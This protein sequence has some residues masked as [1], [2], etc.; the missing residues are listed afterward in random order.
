MLQFCVVITQPGSTRKS[1]EQMSECH[2]WIWHQVRQ[3]TGKQRCHSP[4]KVSPQTASP[5]LW[6]W[7]LGGVYAG[8][9]T[10]CPSYPSVTLPG[11]RLSVIALMGWSPE[12]EPLSICQATV[13]SGPCSPRWPVATPPALCGNTELLRAGRGLSL[14]YPVS[15]PTHPFRWQSHNTQ[16]MWQH[17]SISV[18]IPLLVWL[19]VPEEKPAL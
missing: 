19:S 7:S 1:P 9:R 8:C 17:N 14:A 11:H 4:G 18:L 5:K 12:G 15:S 13:P 3:A 16:S 10:G 2:K 6:W